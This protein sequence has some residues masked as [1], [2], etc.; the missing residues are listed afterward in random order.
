MGGLNTIVIH[1]TCEDSLLATPLILDL[2]V[3]AELFSRIEVKRQ[4]WSDD[5]YT[6]LHP[7][8]SVLSYLC[9][10]PLVS[11]LILVFP[12]IVKNIPRYP[13]VRQ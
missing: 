4:Q 7:V 5:E 3:L 9:K 1:N 11:F 13:M 12:I 10:A 6:T 2:V 8:M